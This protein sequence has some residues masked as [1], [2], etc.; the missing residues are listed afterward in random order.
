[1]QK[2]KNINEQ[3]TCNSHKDLLKAKKL[4]VKFKSYNIKKT[5]FWFN[6]KNQKQKL[7]SIAAYKF[8][9][10]PIFVHPQFVH[11]N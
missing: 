7:F 4:K 3:I 5:Q 10:I 6:N 11:K 8:K 2:K 1:M 9:L